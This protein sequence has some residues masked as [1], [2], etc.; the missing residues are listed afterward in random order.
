MN[1]PRTWLLVVLALVAAASGRQGRVQ[2]QVPEP[3][4]TLVMPFDNVKRD[5]S[6][7]W[8]GEA[9]AVLL[10]DDLN[11]M[12]A[13]AITR[14]QRREAFER[15]QVPQMATLTD[16]TAIRIGQLVGASEVIT[17]SLQL[18]GGTLVVHARGLA[19]ET[20]RISH[21]V[22]ERGP[23]S[24]IFA[25]F[26]RVARSFDAA[27]PPIDSRNHT[28]PPLAAFES[29]IKGLLAETPANA[30]AYLQGALT[31]LPTFDRARLALW[32]LFAEAGEHAR[33]L[34]AVS[35]VPADSAWSRRARY[36]AGLSL[37][38]L[39]RHDEAFA[40]FKALADA[41][42]TAAT[43][44]NIGVAQI[45]RGAAASADPPI[46]YFKQAVDQDRNDPDYCFNLGYAYWLTRD[47]TA[48]IYWLREAVRRNPADGEAHFILGTALGAGGSTV[49]A[50]RERDL[51][52]RLSSV[53]EQWE[54]RPGAEAVPKGLER[55]KGGV[56]LPH[57]RQLETAIANNEQRDQRELARFYLD[58][59]RGLFQQE[60]DSEAIT[61]LNRATFL[62]PY[63]AEAHLLLGRIHL[64]NNRVRAAIDAFKISLW[65][66]ETAPAHA[67]LAQAYLQNKDPDAARLE[68]GRALALD[69]ASAE[70]TDL[71]GRIGVH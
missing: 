22:V 60:N 37:L 66:A 30:V 50:S 68:A 41:Q 43:L 26:E 27:T 2:A 51:A 34:A 57:A 36:L 1:S 18:E 67:A 23:V 16:A 35:P 54:K 48:T 59:G 21:D 28:Y 53:Y 42:P 52:R 39:N 58:R 62:S 24:E 46:E 61:Q 7:F 32:D 12:G 11:A 15:L 3:T 5:A 33:A 44:N 55:V 17:G 20:G 38:T 4:R 31:A 8:L 19:L 6:I 40:A 71:L 64:R 49:E 9:A 63:E 56:E 69:P 47:L 10:T 65:S 25:T 45:R 70:A 29:Y 13:A 14:D